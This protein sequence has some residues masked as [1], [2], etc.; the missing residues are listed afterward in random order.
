M[1]DEKV[2]LPT[3]TAMVVGSM[4][5]SGV[6][7]LPQ[8][9]GAETGVFGALIAW[10]IA[11]V[12]MLM[13]AFVF[14]R[15]A[16]RKPELDAG[17]FAYAKAGFGNYVGFNAA[18]GYWASACAG[19]T[20]YWVLI[21]ATTGA[22]F[23]TLGDGTT[24]VAVLI[25]SAGV[26]LFFAL[27]SRGVQQAAIINRIAT[28][29]KVIPLVV[30]IV[31]AVVL[32]D[33]GYFSDNF[34]GGNGIEV[35]TLWDQVTGTM[36]ITVFVFMGI[37]GASVYSRFAKNRSDVGKATVVGFLGVLGVFALVTLV[38]YG[39]MPQ[40]ELAAAGQPSVASVLEALVGEWGS[41]FIRIGVIVSVLGA[42]LAWTLMAAEV[43]YI[44]SR[45][46]DMPRFLARQNRA[47]APIASLILASGLVQA[48][49]I[50]V[51]FVDDGLDFMLDLTAALTLIPYLLAA[52][53]MAKLVWGEPGTDGRSRWPDAVI[54]GLAVA[55]TIFLVAAAGVD[56]LL[57]SCILYAIGASMYVMARREQRQR[58]FTRAEAVLFGIVVLGAVGGVVYLATGSAD[59][60]QAPEYER[61]TTYVTDPN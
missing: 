15:L 14:Q 42:Y 5:G 23:P 35:G 56:K 57:L 16:I 12:G 20:S 40:G 7:L 25:S 61:H 41:V 37:E 45:S 32:F 39:A 53:Y 28:I 17:I 52:A 58:I 59:V 19:N 29:A 27:I 51:L 2:N 54:A 10:T 43:L 36:L 31:L 38:S 30:F 21:M 8:R 55:Y 1:K 50:V 49:L 48:L 18:F 33:A 4:V 46:A 22:L 9:F 24:V 6:F 44:P 13:L 47:G 26:W 34:W 3:L 11:G 60:H